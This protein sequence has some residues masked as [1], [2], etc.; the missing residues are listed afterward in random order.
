MKME[1]YPH[2]PEK[3]FRTKE[4]RRHLNS[5]LKTNMKITDAMMQDD[6]RGLQLWTILLKSQIVEA[7]EIINKD[8]NDGKN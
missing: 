3:R 4:Y 5:M 7:L 1:N 6:L 2:I 8:E